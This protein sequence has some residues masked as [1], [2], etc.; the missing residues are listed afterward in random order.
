MWNNYMV[1]VTRHSQKIPPICHSK[2]HIERGA[3]PVN[4]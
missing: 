3:V 4:L 2:E 1:E